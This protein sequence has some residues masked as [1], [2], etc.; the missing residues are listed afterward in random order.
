MVGFGILS[1]LFIPVG[2][3]RVFRG[4]PKKAKWG[5]AVD[6]RARENPAALLG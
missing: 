3:F 4:P 1:I 6:G 5:L 2:F